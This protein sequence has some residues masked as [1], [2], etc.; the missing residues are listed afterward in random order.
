M[1]NTI[2]HYKTLIQS[3]NSAAILN[4]RAQRPININAI[5]LENSDFMDRLLAELWREFLGD[6]GE[7]TALLATGGYGRR[8]LHLY[9]DIDLLILVAANGEQAQQ[10]RSALTRF[11][12]AL[13]DIGLKIG[14]NVCNVDEC[15]VLAANDHTIRTALT[16]L[17]HLQ[18][19]ASL[20]DA[21]QQRLADDA[22]WSQPAF[23][24]AKLAERDQRYAKYHETAYNL[25]PNIKEG[26]G[27]LRDIHLLGWIIKHRNSSQDIHDLVERLWITQ[28]EYDELMDNRSFLWA[29]RFALHALTGRCEDRLLF[30]YQK[31]LA[32]EFGCHEDDLNAAV[33]QFMQRYFRTVVS[34]ERLNEMVLQLFREH[35]TV[36]PS[37]AQTREIDESFKILNHYLEVRHENVFADN[38]LKLLDVFL[39]LQREP[40][41][42][43]IGASTIRLIRQNVALI[44]EDFRASPAAS[45]L[46]MEILRQPSGITDQLRQMN[47][48]GL[49][50]A[51]LPEFGRVVGRMQYD[52]FHVYTVDEH[53]LFVV[54]NLRRFALDKFRSDHPHC[55][56]I[57]TLIEKPE[58]LY[59]AGLLHDIAKGSNGDHSVVGETI[60]HAFCKRHGLDAEDT[61]LVQWLVRHHLLMSMTAQRKD[62][63]DPD[64]IHDFAALVRDSNR[65]NHLYLL[66]VADIRATNPNLWNAWKGALL[67]ELFTST[68]SAFRRGL[69]NPVAL[70]DK[71]AFV[72]SEARALLRR[73]GLNEAAITQVWDNIG[74][75]YFLRFHADEIAWHTVAISSSELETLPL[76]LLRPTS[77]RGSAEVF[78]YT[79]NR[80]FIFTQ[81]SAILDQLG[82]TILDA[83]IITTSNR[84]AIN[85]Y[86]VLE[87]NGSPIKDQRRHIQICTRLRECLGNS[88]PNASLPHVQRRQSRQSRH[89]KVP[90]DIRFHDD[91]QNRYSILELISTD[92]PGLL[93]RVGRAFHKHSIRLHNAR[94]STLGSRVEDIFYI[95]D[96]NDRPLVEERQRKELVETLLELVE[97]A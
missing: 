35:L 62:I 82:L 67:R 13:W 2:A 52:L 61:A 66:T 9:A 47:R 55:N 15:V 88:D 71:T 12:T 57:F 84:F 20:S 86:Q 31:D 89:F 50:A 11:T 70:A 6:Y 95:T 32:G 87:Q 53:T 17:R 21:L 33:E 34:I 43:G 8:E 30:D 48:Y 77:H 44:N 73:L 54:S 90:T 10:Q 28:A 96:Q 80:D 3:N 4:F 36:A 51:Y 22:P 41:V 29:V 45:R 91:P 16:E 97:S 7:Q 60:A 23:F 24:A 78:I 38:P 83:R 27:G 56:E 79:H 74:D 1:H 14:H 5:I 46:F 68:R 63:S 81:T 19:A 72:R 85:S 92:R 75:E 18:G 40:G 59:I 69:E 42:L 39:I 76:V 25:E 26:P 64:V 65:L 93:S 94:I 37:S 49:L 58:L